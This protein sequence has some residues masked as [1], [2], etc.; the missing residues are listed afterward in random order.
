MVYLCTLFSSTDAS[1]KY[2]VKIF[3]YEKEF[4]RD[5]ELTYYISSY[6]ISCSC[7]LFEFEGYPCRHMLCLMKVQQVMMLPKKCI[8]KRWTKEAKSTTLY[9]PAQ[10]HVEGQSFTARRGALSRM[11]MDLVDKCYLTE[12]YSSFLMEELHELKSKVK[13]LD[14]GGNTSKLKE[15]NM[16]ECSQSVQD[17]NVVRAK[18]CGKRLKSSK[19]KAMSQNNRSCSICS[20]SGHNK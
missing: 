6:L 19:E 10:N 17:P 1:F 13:D 7:R 18:G 4:L 11:A 9:E 14:I 16:H 12:A 15:S 5:R 3:E 8:K 20:R 2:R